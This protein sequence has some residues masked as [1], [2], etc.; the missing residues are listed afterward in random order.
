M[1]NKNNLKELHDSLRYIES[2][3]KISHLQGVDV[4]F[5]EFDKNKG[6]NC[7]QRLNWYV[8]VLIIHIDFGNWNKK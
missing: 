5:G 6:P 2:S 1:R 7:K 3:I 8:L 4:I